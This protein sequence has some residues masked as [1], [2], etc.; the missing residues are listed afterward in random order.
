V[1]TSAFAPAVYDTEEARVETTS[2][3]SMPLSLAQSYRVGEIRMSSAPVG[4][5]LLRSA[6]PR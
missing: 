5:F 2:S 4:K 6:L 3:K 1:L